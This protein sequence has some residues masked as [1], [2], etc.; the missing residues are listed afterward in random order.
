MQTQTGKCDY[1]TGAQRKE[2]LRAA[3]VA[4]WFSATFRPGPDPGDP[5]L[6]PTL[7]SLH[8]ARFSLCLSLSLSLSVCV[9]LL[10]LS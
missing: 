9:S 6:S 4:Q 7:G 10:C 5:G 8:G 2:A 1:A 3:L